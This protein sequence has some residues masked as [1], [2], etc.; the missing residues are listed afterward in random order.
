MENNPYRPKILIVDDVPENLFVLQKI[1]KKLDCEIISAS[2]GNEALTRVLDHGFA[3]IILDVQMP[4][5]DGYEVAEI[6]QSDE[7]TAEIPIIFVTAIDRDD[8]REIRGYGTGA[9]DFLFKPLNEFILVS[10]VKVFLESHRIKT[11]LEEM[12]AQRTYALSKANQELKDQV[13]K[14]IKAANALEKARSYLENVINAISS[15]LISVD[16]N[17][18]IIDLNEAAYKVCGLPKEAVRGQ[19]LSAVFPFYGDLAGDVSQAVSS[20]SFIEKSRTSIYIAGKLHI[21]D[22]AIYPFRF[23][24]VKGAVIRVDDVT[25]RS[26]IDDMVIQ[27]EKMLSMG[28]IAAGMATEINTPLAGII[29]NTQVIGNR[30]TTPLPANERVARACGTTFGAIRQYMDKRGVQDLMDA[31][32][33]SGKRAVRTVDNV[34]SFSRKSEGPGKREDLAGVIDKTVELACNDYH[35]THS[36]DF[37]SIN[38]KRTFPANMPRVMCQINKMQQ[39]ILNILK[40]AAQAMAEKT[41]Y[42]DGQKQIAITLERSPDN[43]AQILIRDNGPGMAEGVA[44]KIFEPFFTTRKA[45]AGLGLA[46]AYYIISDDHNGFLGIDTEPGK[47]TTLMIKLPL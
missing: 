26:K 30:L 34:I 18:H 1:L 8:A 2:S 31:V 7:K 39:A 38:I 11:G 21:H 42:T 23:S 15:S 41:D 17:C 24:D 27:T 28:E 5:M 33:A 13:E 9:V 3:L 4:E 46:I 35:L 44:K 25:A 19:A 20:D 16:E 43:Y 32:L 12:V 37:K 40:N 22:F 45:N 6:L 14:N 10:K 36:C 29:Q 47:G